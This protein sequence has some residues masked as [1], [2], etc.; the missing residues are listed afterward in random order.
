RWLVPAAWQV[1][2][3]DAIARETLAEFPFIDLL[4]SGDLLLTKTGY[5]SFTEAACN[6]VPVLYVERGD[7]P[8]EPG[9][10][11]WLEAH[12]NARRLHRAQLAGGGLE[13]P[14]RELLARPARPPLAPEGI[15]QAADC[16]N[17]YL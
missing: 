3:P 5:G 12:G 6:G 2:R 9:L 4:C 1:Q 15:D 14:L 13:E 17:G 7:W 16:L 10:T 11:A 8:E